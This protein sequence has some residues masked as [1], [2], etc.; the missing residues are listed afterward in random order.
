MA[1]SWVSSRTQV[2]FDAA[3]GCPGAA[4]CGTAAGGGGTGAGGVGK[5]AAM[6]P[7]ANAAPSAAAVRL[8]GQRLML[9]GPVTRP[10]DGPIK[11]ANGD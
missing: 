5:G 4:G 8:R 1:A 2:G 9:V 3:D 6:A 7:V 11:P 10:S